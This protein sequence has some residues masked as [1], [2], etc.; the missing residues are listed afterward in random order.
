MFPLKLLVIMVGQ[1]YCHDNR[2]NVTLNFKM[3]VH[4]F[5]FEVQKQAS[6]KGQAYHASSHI[7]P[8]HTWQAKVNSLLISE[9]INTLVVC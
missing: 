4:T 7:S 3:S 2:L 8:F 9:H 1:G 5:S 6:Q